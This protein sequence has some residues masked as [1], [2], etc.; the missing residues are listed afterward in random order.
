MLMYFENR[1][2]TIFAVVISIKMSLNNISR[3][4]DTRIHFMDGWVTFENLKSNQ[5]P[6]TSPFNLFYYGKDLGYNF[7]LEKEKSLSN[8]TNRRTEN[9][10]KAFLHSS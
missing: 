6:I 8:E 10:K 3:F 7:K 2:S 4:P 5:L 9:L 1:F